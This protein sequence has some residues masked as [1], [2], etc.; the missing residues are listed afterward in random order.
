MASK[1]K[2]ND[3]VDQIRLCDKGLNDKDLCNILKSL[4]TH[5]KSVK[6]IQAGGNRLSEVPIIV[7]FPNIREVVLWRNRIESI[8]GI[9]SRLFA[10]G[11]TE[12][13]LAENRI[14]DIPNLCAFTSLERLILVRNKLTV[15]QPNYLPKSLEL[16]YLCSNKLKAI[17]SLE[18]HT[19]LEYLSL[20]NN[21][22][23]HINTE[24][25]PCSLVDL[26]LAGNRITELPDFSS[27]DN[28]KELELQQ[29]AITEV[30]GVIPSS[31]QK[32]CL[33]D[34]HIRRISRSTILNLQ[35]QSF[36]CLTTSMSPS[37]TK[38]IEWPTWDIFEKSLQFLI[39]S[40]LKE[41]RRVLDAITG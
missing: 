29:N 31:L 19:K 23:E 21:G 37:E 6:I 38:D 12:L 39:D 7:Q 11:I 2:E 5:K 17:P 4:K 10:P 40:V 36:E 8:S 34:N 27:F 32:L 1:S 15:I 41:E 16:L 33:R 20:G 14:V 30:T 18:S 3:P 9:T 28:L 13:D 25:F 26:S 22:L 24:L 35:Q